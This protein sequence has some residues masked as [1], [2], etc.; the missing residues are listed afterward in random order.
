MA[1]L[2]PIQET[3]NPVPDGSTGTISLS[4]QTDPGTPDETADITIMLNGIVQQSASAVV[5]TGR[6]AEVT[7]VV[8]IGET[9]SGWEIRTDAGVLA[10]GEAPN[11]FTIAHS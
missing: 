11:Q 9:G 3:P 7:P 6:S 5:L 8:Q 1:T 10:A 2:N 4:F